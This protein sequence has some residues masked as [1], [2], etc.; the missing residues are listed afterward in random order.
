MSGV[1]RYRPCLDIYHTTA[2]GRFNFAMFLLFQGQLDVFPIFP[3]DSLSFS[4]FLAI[5]ILI[6]FSPFAVSP[7]FRQSPFT[8]TPVAASFPPLA[9]RAYPI[10]F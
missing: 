6:I 3:I 10:F 8:F 9:R 2:R 1:T 5:I 4:F 7:P